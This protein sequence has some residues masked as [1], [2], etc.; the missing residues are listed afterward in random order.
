MPNFNRLAAVAALAA[1]AGGL[2]GPAPLRAR[3]GKGDQYF[4]EGARDAEKKDY[5]A[6]LA[7]YQKALAEDPSEIAYQIAVDKT[8]VN[9]SFDH[10]EKG[11]KMRDQGNLVDALA[12]FRRAFAISPADTAA[13][14]E[15]LRTQAMIERERRRVE[16]TGKQAPAEVRAETPAEE[17][18]Q[19]VREK[20]DRMLPLPEL[21]PLNPERI[22]LKINSQPPKVLFDT[23]AKVAGLN[24]IWDPDYQQGRSVS[25]DLSNSTVEEALDDAALLTKSFWKPLPGGNTIFVTN[26]NRNKRNDYEDQVLKVFYLS[27]VNTPQE[28]QEIVNAVRA[29]TELTRLMPYNSLHAII[30]RGEADRIAL[31]E[32]IIN[33][34][35]RPKAEVVIDVIVL[36]ASS[37][38]SKQITAALASTGL[39]LPVTFNPRSSI[40]ITTNTNSTNTTNTNNGTTNTS[41]TN[42]ANASVGSTPSPFVPL[43]NLSHL[44]S[45]DFAITLPGAL[46]QAALSNAN[47]KILQSPE[48]R[49]VDNSKAS[50][51]IGEREPTATGS[52]QPGIGGVGINPLVNTQF[53]YIDVGVNVDITPQVH[54]NGEVSMHVELDISSV[55]GYVNLGGINQPIIQQNKVVHDLRVREGEV[56]LLAG[57]SQQQDTSTITGIPGLSSIPIIG[58]LFKGRNVDH[59]KSELIIALIPHIVRRPDVT[60]ENLKG[61]AVGNAQTVKLN[62][63]PRTTE[64]IQPKPPAGTPAAPAGQAPTAPG[65]PQAPPP[66]PGGARAF[67]QPAQVDT[68]AGS[69]VTISLAAAGVT[70]AIS[71]PMQIHYDPKILRLN[72]I[73]TGDLMAQGNQQPVFTKN[74]Q[75]DAGTA[76]VQLTR[77]PGAP[78]ASGA[79][80]LVNLVFQA[81]GRGVTSVTIPNLTITGAQGQPV[82]GGSPQVTV[83]VK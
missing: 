9:A 7:A 38:I 25:L 48:V 63:A 56:S 70:G 21:K 71:A 46:L 39:N 79:G 28:L 5:D 37:D 44:S 42:N 18:K 74:I 40:Q 13:S 20:I 58:N 75:N 77:P 51:K 78:A 1:L 83:N 35:D 73:T 61:I 29:V 52:F 72:D 33:D 57:L 45:A 22:T 19:E 15:I 36:Q 23:V 47:T 76:T 64:I 54:E 68:T 69:S 10:L 16:Q 11:L 14:Q 81:V 66:P 6:A 43:S 17:A 3:T 12:E 32:K 55:A 24:V 8:R 62:Y 80:T 49:S 34:L 26:D 65:G 60:P 59:S 27:N 67:F 31:A 53:T 82:L 41:T 4:A 30:A 2:V 50:L